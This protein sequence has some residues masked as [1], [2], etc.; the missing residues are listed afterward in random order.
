MIGIQ[1]ILLINIK[2]DAILKVNGYN[3]E[4]STYIFL[5]KPDKLSS[6]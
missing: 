5:G 1:F 2:N 6:F 3:K 4:S